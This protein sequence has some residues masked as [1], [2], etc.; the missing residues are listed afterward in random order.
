M[1][2]LKKVSLLDAIQATCLYGAKAYVLSEI[3]DGTAISELAY[4]YECLIE[5][6]EKIAN[7]YEDIG[8][9]RDAVHKDR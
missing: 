8:E 5:I 2:V 9:D 4:A 7:L 3:E 1:K 6:D